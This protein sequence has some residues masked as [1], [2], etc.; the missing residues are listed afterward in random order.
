MMG[1]HWI[2]TIVYGIIYPVCL[3]MLD[4]LCAVINVRE[5]WALLILLGLHLIYLPLLYLIYLN[6]KSDYDK[7]GEKRN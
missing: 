6:H 3:F 1:K 5:V 7:Q 4:C 2:F